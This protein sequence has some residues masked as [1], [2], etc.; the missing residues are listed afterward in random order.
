MKLV[1]V[2]SLIQILLAVLAFIGHVATISRYFNVD[3]TPTHGSINIRGATIHDDIA[4]IND[5][6]VEVY[7]KMEKFDS[8]TYYNNVKNDKERQF[9]YG[10]KREPSI[11]KEKLSTKSRTLVFCINALLFIA[12]GF[13]GLSSDK[14]GTKVQT[15]ISLIFSITAIL[16]FTIFVLPV[17]VIAISEHTKEVKEIDKYEEIMNTA[18]PDSERWTNYKEAYGLSKVKF[19]SKSMVSLYS[20]QVIIGNIVSF[21]AFLC[22]ILLCISL[23]RSKQS[24]STDGSPINRNTSLASNNIVSALDIDIRH[25]DSTLDMDLPPKYEDLLDVDTVPPQ[26]LETFMKKQDTV[27]TIL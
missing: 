5:A 7:E 9:E 1:Q 8:P 23:C 11:K 21:L 26:Y 27:Y 18:N 25:H 3:F 6:N 16:F 13:L 20:A 17:F 10:R 24:S 15:M 22:S 12:S 14:P 19:V 2:F 4:T